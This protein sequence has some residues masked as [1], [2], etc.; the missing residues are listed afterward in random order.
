MRGMIRQNTEPGK[1][2]DEGNHEKRN[3]AESDPSRKIFR[4]STF[5]VQA[6]FGEGLFPHL[7]LKEKNR[8]H[9]EDEKTAVKNAKKRKGEKRGHKGSGTPTG[10]KN[11]NQ[12][13][14]QTIGHHGCILYT[15]RN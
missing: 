15:I 9:C 12:D 6:E 2:A 4:N 10:E 14:Q 11:R 13:K 1:K 8:E 5:A 7:P 3:E